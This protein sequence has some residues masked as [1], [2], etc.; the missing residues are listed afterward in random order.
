MQLN[1]P[2]KFS[3]VDEGEA[4]RHLGIT[5]DAL[6]SLVQSGRLRAY[7]G[8]GKGSFF[9]VSDLDA[10][11]AELHPAE[12]EARPSA[13]GVPITLGGLGA[14]R[15][16]QDPAMKVHLRLQ[17]DLKWYDLT[18]DDFASWVRELHPAAYEKNRGNIT[19]VIGTLQHLLDLIDAAAAT[20][21]HKPSSLQSP[22]EDAPE[23]APPVVGE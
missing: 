9:R 5:R 19:R 15:K 10:L 23:D 3:F 21:E 7:P 2:A 4:V 20:W 8:V 11:A 13:G 17:A 1:R 16:Q 18:E 12:A 6:L 14:A 22:T